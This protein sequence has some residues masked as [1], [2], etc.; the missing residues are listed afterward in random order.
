MAQVVRAEL[1]AQSTG[2]PSP[3]LG[4]NFVHLLWLTR[5]YLGHL[6][7]LF[8]PGER[9]FHKGAVREAPYDISISIEACP[10]CHTGGRRGGGV[11]LGERLFGRGA[12]LHG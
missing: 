5:R 7:I 11:G 9:Y 1:P 6:G 3:L 10:S 2:Y 12:L 4:N 8:V